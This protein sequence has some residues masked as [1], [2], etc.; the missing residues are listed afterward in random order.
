M[1]ATDGRGFARFGT[2]FKEQGP[3]GGKTKQWNDKQTLLIVAMHLLLVAVDQVSQT[4]FSHTS[5]FKRTGVRPCQEHRHGG[6][7][8]RLVHFDPHVPGANSI[9]VHST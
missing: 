1:P 6:A 5:V 2:T 7:Y 4:Y 3:N 8:P 9:S